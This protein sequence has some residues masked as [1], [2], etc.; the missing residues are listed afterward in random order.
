VPR[1]Y[2]DNYSGLTLARKEK[3]EGDVEPLTCPWPSMNMTEK[4]R[5]KKKRKER[6]TPI[7]GAHDHQACGCR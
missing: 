1:T 7:P 6:G 2:P 4:K 3:G 5:K